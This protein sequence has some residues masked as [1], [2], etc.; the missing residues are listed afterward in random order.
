MTPLCRNKKQVFSKGCLHARKKII[1]E[2]KY[3]IN[4]LG[5]VVFSAKKQPFI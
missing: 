4:L 3:F 5:S 1:D 2:E